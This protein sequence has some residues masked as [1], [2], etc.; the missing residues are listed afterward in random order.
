[1]KGNSQQ[2]YLIIS[3]K[4]M[5]YVCS[6]N[7]FNNHQQSWRPLSSSTKTTGWKWSRQHWV[8]PQFAKNCCTSQSSFRRNAPSQ[9]QR[10]V[11]DVKYLHATSSRYSC[12]AEEYCR[13]QSPFKS[14]PLYGSSWDAT[15]GTLTKLYAPLFLNI[16]L[17]IAFH[18]PAEQ[19]SVRNATQ[20][21]QSDMHNPLLTSENF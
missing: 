5:T 1:M 19:Y 18:N 21:C 17:S 16:C 6:W 3:V 8:I 12:C 7:I 9:D 14:R 20:G 4:I 2:S 13:R 10:Q 11:D 15:A